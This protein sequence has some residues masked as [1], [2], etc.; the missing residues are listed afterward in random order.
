MKFTKL[1]ADLFAQ[2]QNYALA[3]CIAKD[4]NMGAGIATQFVKR[5][6]LMRDFLRGQDPKIGQVISF[7][8]GQKPLVL[9]LITKKKSS[10]K[11]TREDFNRTIENLKAYTEANNITHLAIP[12]IG[13]GLD[14]LDWADSELHIKEVFADTGIE[15]I[16][17]MTPD[18]KIIHDSSWE[19]YYR[20]RGI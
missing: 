6:P 10:G 13:A 8:E 17:C 12:L 19:R 15:I 2:P 7:T 18:S 16:L 5:Y 14:K 11:P 9:N 4:A 20:V 1:E 3:H